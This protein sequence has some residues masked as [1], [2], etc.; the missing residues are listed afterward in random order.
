ML[1]Q[2]QVA[3]ML[4]I[5][6]LD[7]M[8]VDE[9]HKIHPLA[10]KSGFGRIFCSPTLFE[11]MVK[12]LLL[13]CCGWP[14]SLQMA[15]ALCNMHQHKLHGYKK[16]KKMKRNIILRGEEEEGEY[17]LGTF[18][19][20]KEIVACMDAQTL[21][22][23]CNLG[24]RASIILELATNIENGSLNLDDLETPINPSAPTYD[25]ATSH[26]KLVWNR[27]IGIK[28]FG[29]FTVA[30]IMMCIGFY[31]Y[32]PIDSETIKHLTQASTFFY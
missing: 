1:D 9:F 22:K 20:P 26:H 29:A 28:G 14:R 27:L 21:N 31:Q 23:Y 19:S 17:C 8:M 10:K 30:N 11:D 5:S 18:P 15:Q 6:R 13:C 32:I 16:K 4:R 7:E 25:L 3:R 24:F 2:C 12:S